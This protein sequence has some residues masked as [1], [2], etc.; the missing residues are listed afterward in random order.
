MQFVPHDPH[1]SPSSSEI[2]NLAN[3]IGM[4]VEE[5]S[6]M[7]DIPHDALKK[8]LPDGWLRFYDPESGMVYFDSVTRSLQ[9]HPLLD[10]CKK[11]YHERKE[12][13][14]RTAKPVLTA[15][16]TGMWSPSAISLPSKIQTQSPLHK[17]EQLPTSTKTETLPQASTLQSQSN[18]KSTSKPQIASEPL[19]LDSKVFPR[20]D[21]L[22]DFKKN[23]VEALEDPNFLIQFY[24]LYQETFRKM[25]SS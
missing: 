1:Y 21:V 19:P 11:R 12:Q 4:N 25:N 22:F 16:K 15:P 7:L 14:L 6:D 17:Q 23:I 9:P 20:E 13:K 18:V 10:E 2:L 3:L 24:S 5:D 8:Q